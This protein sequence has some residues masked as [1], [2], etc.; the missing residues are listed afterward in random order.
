MTMHSTAAATVNSAQQS[1]A[2]PPPTSPADP[3]LYTHQHTPAAAMQHAS[4][5]NAIRHCCPPAAHCSSRL[6]STHTVHHASPQ[7]IHS[8]SD[9]TTKVTQTTS[10]AALKQL[11]PNRDWPPAEYR[12][13]NRD[14]GNNASTCSRPC[15]YVCSQPITGALPALQHCWH[16]C[17][18]H[19]APQ[20][21]AYPQLP[22]ATTAREL[23]TCQLGTTPEDEEMSRAATAPHLV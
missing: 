14:E 7:H 15:L 1:L 23:L 16:P 13:L 9:N 2:P 20:G 5:S 6:Q 4:S 10:S 19:L 3:L 22:Q 21:A 17:P 12:G 18:M 11:L 8:Y